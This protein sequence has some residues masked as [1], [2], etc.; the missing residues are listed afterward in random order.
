MQTGTPENG[1][2][3]VSHQGF[4]E[5][6]TVCCHLQQEGVEH[7]AIGSVELI[8]KSCWR[9]LLSDEFS[10]E[11]IDQLR[12]MKQWRS[13]KKEFIYIHVIVVNLLDEERH[14]QSMLCDSSS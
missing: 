8:T 10:M 4:A 3:H 5:L 14:F 6:S 9:D 7:G 11:N 2:H 13:Q 1:D 12:Y